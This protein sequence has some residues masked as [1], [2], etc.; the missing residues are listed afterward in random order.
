VWQQRKYEFYDT[1]N[2]TACFVEAEML[3]LFHESHSV[4]LLQT[5][6][7]GTRESYDIISRQGNSGLRLQKEETDRASPYGRLYLRNT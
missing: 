3:N 4:H 2:T 7:R 6:L 5:F 1:R